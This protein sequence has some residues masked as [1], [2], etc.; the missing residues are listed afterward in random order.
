VTRRASARGRCLRKEQTELHSTALSNGHLNYGDSGRISTF[1]DCSWPRRRSRFADLHC[2][3]VEL[4]PG[5]ERLEWSVTVME[6]AK[7]VGV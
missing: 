6:L 1:I 5:L 3:A 2:T 7:A 4:V